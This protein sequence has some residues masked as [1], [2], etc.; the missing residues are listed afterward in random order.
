MFATI[1]WTVFY[2]ACSLAIIYAGCMVVL[3]MIGIVFVKSE[4]HLTE[5]EEQAIEDKGQEE[6]WKR[7]HRNL[8]IGRKLHEHK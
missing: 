5:K 6:V 3:L 4:K 1:F 2:I 7:L 8:E